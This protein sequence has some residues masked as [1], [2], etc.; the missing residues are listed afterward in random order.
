MPED[1]Y[2]RRLE[3]LEAHLD[4]VGLSGLAADLRD[5]VKGSATS[6]EAIVMAGGVLDRILSSSNLDPALAS[7]AALAKAHGHALFNSQPWPPED[8]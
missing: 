3:E 6:S 5:A 1:N 2:Y 8:G 7:Q 4:R